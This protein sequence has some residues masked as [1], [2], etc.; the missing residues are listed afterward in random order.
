MEPI[1]GNTPTIK[2]DPT[3]S[4]QRFVQEVEDGVVY[5]YSKFGDGEFDAMLKIT[6][7][8][9]NCNTNGDVYSDKIQ[10]ALLDV[11][12][13][14]PPYRLAVAGVAVRHFEKEIVKFLKENNMLD[15]EYYHT[16]VFHRAVIRSTRAGRKFPLLPVLQKRGAIIVGPG[17]LSNI[18]EIFPVL[19]FYQTPECNLIE[20]ID[21]AVDGVSRLCEQFKDPVFVSISG[22]LAAEPLI[23]ELYKRFGERHWFVDMGS[24]WDPYVGVMSRQYMRDW[25]AG[26]R[27]LT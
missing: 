22:G 17:H 12:L 2:V 18:A 10:K 19:G 20:T 26:R 23:H 6:K 9:R 8:K 24:V 13:S 7:R 3:G 25:P 4:A 14:N 11:F 27:P 1:R 15:R 21:H 16:G 5:T